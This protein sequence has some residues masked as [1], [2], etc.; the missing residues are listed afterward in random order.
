MRQRRGN[1]A[2]KEEEEEEK[3]KEEYLLRVIERKKTE[4]RSVE[5]Q[6]ILSSVPIISY[7]YNDDC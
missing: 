6:H 1:N 7:T 5:A 3:E 4:T 2:E